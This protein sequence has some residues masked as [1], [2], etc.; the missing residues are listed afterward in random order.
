MAND[1][2]RILFGV[3]TSDFD[4]MKTIRDVGY[5]YAEMSVGIAFDPTKSDAKPLQFSQICDIG[6]AD[7]ETE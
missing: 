4:D 7:G 3:C 6:Y 5:D 1:N 2:G